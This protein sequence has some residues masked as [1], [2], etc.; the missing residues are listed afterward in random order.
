MNWLT[1]FVRPKIQ[2]IMGNHPSEMPDDLWHKCP[3]CEQMIFHRELASNI[4]VCPNCLYHMRINTTERFN[5]LFDNQEYQLIPLPKVQE[6]PLKFKDTKKYSDRLKNYRAKTNQEDAI[7]VAHGKVNQIETVIAVMSFDFMGGSMGVYVGHAF[8]A[9]AEWA[10]KR[11]TPMVVVTASGGARMQ[12]GMLSL[13]QM[14][15]T[16]IAVD[17]LHAAKIPYIVILTD[18]TMGGVSASFAMLG[19]VIIAESGALI[20]FAGPRVIEETIKQKLPVGFQ[21]AE[22]LREHGM[23][24]IVSDR[25]DLKKKLGLVLS[26]LGY[27]TRSTASPDAESL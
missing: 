1:E 4:N 20:G 3:K 15:T 6:D 13:M 25:K 5:L 26:V 9:A 14:P 22:F 12:E 24:D 16:V 8:H 19:D 7:V 17:A 2:A 27:H 11:K 10:I 18:P 23:I 21:K